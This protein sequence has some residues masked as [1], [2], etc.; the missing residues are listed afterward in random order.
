M[1]RGFEGSETVLSNVMMEDTCHY[2]FV[3]I[4]RVHDTKNEA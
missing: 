3:K 1:F 2:I 4:H